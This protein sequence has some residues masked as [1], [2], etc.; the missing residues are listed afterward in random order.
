MGM[1]YGGDD[2]H[3]DSS[4]MDGDVTRA[5]QYREPC[6]H[7]KSRW[8]LTQRCGARG[9]DGAR[10]DSAIDESASHLVLRVHALHL[11]PCDTSLGPWDGWQPC[12]QA[13]FV[14][15][16]LLC[17]ILRHEGGP[18]RDTRRRMTG[19]R[20]HSTAGGGQHE[21]ERAVCAECISSAGRNVSA[22]K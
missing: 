8:L 5:S 19:S 9:S 3:M 18:S 6:S 15:R 12:R 17:I 2:V 20:A 7:R 10:H 11:L 16:L 1:A 22:L 4:L 14:G 21:G 13:R